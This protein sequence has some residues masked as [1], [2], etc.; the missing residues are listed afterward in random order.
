MLALL[1]ADQSGE[2]AG[3]DPILCLSGIRMIFKL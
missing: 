3:S 1:L 2:D